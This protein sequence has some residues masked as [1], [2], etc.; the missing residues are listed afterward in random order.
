MSDLENLQGLWQI[1]Q[2]LQDGQPA[3]DAG[4]LFAIV[5]KD[6]RLGL[7]FRMKSEPRGYGDAVYTIRLDPSQSPKVIEMTSLE[8][9]K[10][11]SGIYELDGD[12][13]KLCWARGTKGPLP[14][15]FTCDQ[16]SNRRL[17]VL[18]RSA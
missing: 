4:M 1:E 7:R 18:S 17:F 5:V 2:L 13:L 9:G 3:P 6:N 8:D 14:S 15:E 12:A 11:Y 10:A 16:G